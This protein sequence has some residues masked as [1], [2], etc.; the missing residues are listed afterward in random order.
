F[1]PRLCQQWLD[2]LFFQPRTTR[3]LLLNHLVLL[4]TADST[5][6]ISETQDGLIMP[7]HVFNTREI[8]PRYHFFHK[9]VL[10]EKTIA[11]SDLARQYFSAARGFRIRPSRVKER[12]H[13]I[14]P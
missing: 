13:P 2:N 5:P 6:A 14:E 10:V 1:D 8:S 4:R 3:H 11:F 12:S 7:S 9:S